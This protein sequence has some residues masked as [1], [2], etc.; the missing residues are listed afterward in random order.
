M[1]KRKTIIIL[2]LLFFCSL[3]VFMVYWHSE[4]EILSNL[5]LGIIASFLTIIILEVLDFI[6]DFLEFAFLRGNYKRIKIENGLDNRDDNTDRKYKDMTVDYD[7]V[8][9]IIKLKYK[10]NGQYR[11]DLDYKE[12]HAN[13]T[14]N[15]NKENKH[16][17]KGIYFYLFKHDDY[18]KYMPDQGKY[19]IVVEKSMPIRIYVYFNN[20]IPS[21]LAYGYEIWEKL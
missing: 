21:R 1:L 15:L 12:G 9:P 2:F 19:E 8:N 11:G 13:F 6:Y 20:L 4:C 3:F 17:G 14:I 5:L 16:L 10:G 7:K 18:K